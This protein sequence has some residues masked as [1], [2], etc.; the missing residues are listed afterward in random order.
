VRINR[1]KGSAS[2]LRSKKRRFFQGIEGKKCL[3]G[4]VKGEMD[5]IQEVFL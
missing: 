1:L 5:T 3:G 4:D 2:N